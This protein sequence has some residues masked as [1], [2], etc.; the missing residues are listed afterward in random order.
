MLDVPP[1]A[2]YRL[3][4]KESSAPKTRTAVIEEHSATCALSSQS[5]QEKHFLHS[6]EERLAGLA[7]ENDG[8]GT[9]VKSVSSLPCY[10]S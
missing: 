8:D 4:K 9:T 2:D 3:R 10:D 5:S 6:N 7:S 1:K